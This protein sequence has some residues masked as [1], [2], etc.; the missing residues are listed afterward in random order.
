MSEDSKKVYGND[1][2]CYLAQPKRKVWTLI[3]SAV[4]FVW[5]KLLPYFR[6][7]V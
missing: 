1:N 5:D 6:F 3:N 4:I 7:V 2:S